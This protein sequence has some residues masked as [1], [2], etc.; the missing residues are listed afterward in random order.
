MYYTALLAF[1]NRHSKVAED[2]A[3]CQNIYEG[4]G[5]IWSYKYVTVIAVMSCTAH[6]VVGQC[7]HLGKWI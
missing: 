5:L 7:S 6:L 2:N 3:K 4:S 1:A